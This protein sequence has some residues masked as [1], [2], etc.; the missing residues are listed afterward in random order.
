VIIFLLI[1]FSLLLKDAL[2]SPAAP[3]N[4]NHHPKP[5]SSQLLSSEK[6][7]LKSGDQKHHHISEVAMCELSAKLWRVLH[8]Y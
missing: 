2:S 5:E 6:M 4:I 3:N 1:C 8:D 7:S